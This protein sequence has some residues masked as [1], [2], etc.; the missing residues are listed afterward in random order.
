M[1]VP[2]VPSVVLPVVDA[3]SLDVPPGAHNVVVL[4]EH[5]DAP[6][7]QAEAVFN[8]R[9]VVAFAR[10]RTLDTLYIMTECVWDADMLRHGNTAT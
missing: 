2:L 4:L 5:Q 3:L 10:T 7:Q 8:A 6:M 9:A 1:Q